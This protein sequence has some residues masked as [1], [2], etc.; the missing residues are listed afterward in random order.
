MDVIIVDAYH[1][2][3]YTTPMRIGNVTSVRVH[4]AV[5]RVSVKYNG[6]VYTINGR[7]T[8]NRYK[9]REGETVKGTLEIRTY[10]DGTVSYDIIELE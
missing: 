5:H 6:V 3:S 9:D 8:Y 10:D 2:G 7:D 4:P 1:R